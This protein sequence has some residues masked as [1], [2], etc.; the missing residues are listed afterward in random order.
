LRLFYLRASGSI[1]NHLGDGGIEHEIELYI[2]PLKVQSKRKRFE[3]RYA[4]ILHEKGLIL[5]ELVGRET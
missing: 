2:Y 4:C 5:D 1:T 3:R